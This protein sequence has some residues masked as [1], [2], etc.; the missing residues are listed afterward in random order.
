MKINFLIILAI[1]V[2]INIDGKAESSFF[3]NDENSSEKNL[4]LDNE[5]QVLNAEYNSLMQEHK[6]LKD[7]NTALKQQYEELSNKFKTA[8]HN[9]SL[10]FENLERNTLTTTKDLHSDI[11]ILENKYNKI[12]E[13]NK[14]LKNLQL[15]SQKQY[16]KANNDFNNFRDSAINQIQVLQQVAKSNSEAIEKIIND[17]DTKIQSISKATNTLDNK[18]EHTD[19]N[20][21]KNMLY[22]IIAIFI[23]ALF[24]LIIF[25][26]LRKQIFNQKNDI[27]INLKNTRVALEEEGIKLDNKLIELLETQF[28]IIKNNFSDN[29]K[30]AD[31]TLALKVAD[32][33]IR[34]QKNLTLMDEKTKGLKQLA[35]SV[36]RI[37]DNFASNGYEL[38]EMLGKQYSDGMKVTANFILDEDLGE[39]QQIVTRIIK[40]Q[41]NYKGVMIQSAE[42][43]V[44]QGQ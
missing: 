6:I 41:V 12:I 31:H 3:N 21:S 10:S 28:E 39:N 18:I 23:L 26:L 25:I 24:T 2:I 43:E 37:Q 14:A 16:I 4:T 13:D 19:R 27:E 11:Q 36:K 34:I 22:W 1:F 17:L 32:E 42:I 15:D 7:S 35:A 5:F 38:V 44:S 30:E 33:I 40:P 9:I 8:E 20:V 29:N